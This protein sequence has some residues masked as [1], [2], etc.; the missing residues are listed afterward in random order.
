ME[1]ERKSKLGEQTLPREELLLLL[2]SGTTDGMLE[3]VHGEILTRAVQLDKLM[4]F[5]HLTSELDWA[6]FERQQIGFEC[7]AY[8][9]GPYSTYKEYNVDAFVRWYIKTL[10]AGASV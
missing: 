2:K 6:I 5:W 3:K 7:R 1:L 4:A 9:P 10:A 8:E